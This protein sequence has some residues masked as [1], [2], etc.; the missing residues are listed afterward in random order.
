M[1]I[2]LLILRTTCSEDI[3]FQYFFVSLLIKMNS[4]LFEIFVLV[5]VSRLFFVYVRV[6]IITIISTI[7]CID[8]LERGTRRLRVSNSQL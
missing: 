8:I 2:Q 7:V 5:R 1:Q 4:S 3:K 6:S